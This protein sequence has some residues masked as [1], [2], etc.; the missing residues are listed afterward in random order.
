[1]A[2][3]HITMTK[4]ACRGRVEPQSSLPSSFEDGAVTRQAVT[5]DAHDR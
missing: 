3:T 5:V 1:M 2:S 4:I